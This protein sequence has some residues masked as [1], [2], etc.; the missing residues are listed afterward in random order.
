MKLS[1]GVCLS[2][3]IVSALAMGACGDSAPTPPT[4]VAPTP[5]PTPT[6][7]PTP[8]AV[9]TCTPRADARLRSDDRLL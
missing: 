4:A 8:P 9:G 7:E 6:P 1:T 3:A 2:L 5:A